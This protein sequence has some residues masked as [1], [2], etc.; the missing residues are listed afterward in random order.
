MSKIVKLKNDDKRFK[1]KAGDLLEVEPYWLDPSK[2]TVIQR[3]PDGYN[4]ECNVY[5]YEVE[6]IKLKRK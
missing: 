5:S 6:P 1:L 2:Y 3:I 4:P